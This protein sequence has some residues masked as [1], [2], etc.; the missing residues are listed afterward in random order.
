MRTLIQADQTATAPGPG[1][2]PRPAPTRGFAD[3]TNSAPGPADRTAA[4]PMEAADRPEPGGEAFDYPPAYHGSRLARLHPDCPARPVDWRWQRAGVMLELGLR[5]SRR[6]DGPTG[7]AKAY[8]AA[9]RRCRD[10]AGRARLDARMPEVAAARSIRDG[11]PGLRRA[12]EARLLAG[13]DPGRIAAELGLPAG[14]IDRFGR[15]FFDVAGQLGARG[16]VVH[17]VIGLW[18]RPQAPPDANLL[19]RAVAYFGGP[20]ALAAL[21]G[22]P[23]FAALAAGGRAGRAGPVV[24]P[25]PV[26]LAIAAI[27]LDPDAGSRAG[28]ML[29][30]R[31]AESERRYRSEGATAWA[32]PPI[33]GASAPGRPGSPAPAG[34]IEDQD[35]P[36][37]GT[38][39]VPPAAGASPVP[40]G[41]HEGGHEP[42][43]PPTGGGGSPGPSRVGIDGAGASPTRCSQPGVDARGYYSRSV[44]VG[45][46]V[47]RVYLG[48]GEVARVAAGLDD[49]RRRA[50]LARR[51]EDAAVAAAEG[52]LRELGR[53]ADRALGGAREA[54]GQRR[55]G[56]AAR[57]GTGPEGD[58]AGMP[59]PGPAACREGGP[60]PRPD[61]AA[62]GRLPGGERPE[63]PGSG[64]ET[65]P[66]NRPGPGGVTT[67]SPWPPRPPGPG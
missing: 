3:T 34:T 45:G 22:S 16:Y 40:G 29:L 14:A 67:G 52:L 24:G 27:G 5:R 37:A 21:E 46:K 48:K 25:G 63:P 61:V 7:E 53:A 51:A 18:R 12:V 39:P 44:R 17:Q 33:A 41:R 60:G 43:G 59:A 9:W 36:G 56:R 50:R 26:A 42:D 49:Q 35:E 31:L 28:P 55:G 6:D 8:R 57:W 58:A 66:E 10:D 38:G 47:R 4:D 2:R 13:L 11:D 54:A 62:A 32:S 1:L 20:A 30:L 15:L 65:P 19:S 23:E 64:P